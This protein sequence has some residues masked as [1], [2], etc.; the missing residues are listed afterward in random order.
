M[1]RAQLAIAAVTTTLAV[2][3][4]GSVAGASPDRDHDA[5]L[6]RQLD[7]LVAVGAVGAVAEVRDGD[8]VWRSASGVAEIGKHRGVPVHGRFRIG[9]ITKTFLA[10]VVLQLADEHRLRLDDSIEKW[11]PGT[12]PDGRAITI[13]QLL[14]HTSGL[15]DFQHTLTMPPSPAFLDYRWRT[16]TADEQIH[17]ALA[18]PPTSDKPGSEFSYSNTGY[19]LLGQIVER[20][21]DSSYGDEIKRRIIRPLKLHDT[22]LPGTYP[23]IRGPHPHGY[24]PVNDGSGLRLVDFTEMNPSLFGAAGEMISSTKDL[25]TFFDALLEG[26]L[27]PRH[28]LDE[29][30]VPGDEDATYG[31]G[32]AWHTTTCGVRVYGNDGDAVAYEAWSYATEDGHRQATVAVTHGLK[33]DIDDAVDAFLDEAFCD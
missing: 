25:N 21:T 13:R 5:G 32:L 23:R 1:K 33:H 4:S 22:S 15:Y 31:L 17:R 11:L 8:N 19:L 29:M 20:A 3:A 24:V 2:I 9:S 12:V 28:L 16:W 7:E 18:N 14:D 26:Q 27:L 10:T 6:H 30:K